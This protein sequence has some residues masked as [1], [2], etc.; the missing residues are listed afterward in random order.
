MNSINKFL[1]L[2]F[3]V[4]AVGACDEILEPEKSNIYTKDRVYNDPLFAEGLML[5]G[6]SLLPVSYGSE[7]VATDDA[8]SNDKT[9]SYLRMATGQWSANYDPMSI[10]GTCYSAI[11]NLNY[12]FTIADDASWSWES[13]VRNEMFKRRLKGEAYALRAYHHMRLLMYYGGTATDGTLRGV[14]YVTEVLNPGNDDWKKSRGTY[15]EC[16]DQIMA[17]FNQATA[18]L[19][20][21]WVNITGYDD[22]T[23]VYGAHNKNRINSQIIKA[24]KARLALHAASP[25][26]NSGSYNTAKCVTAATLA[27]ELLAEIGGANGL[28]AAGLVYYDADNDIN[29]AEVLW[30]NNTYSS[31]AKEQT[32]FPPSLYGNGDINP[33][34]NLVDAFPMVN[35]YPITASGSGYNP[36][37]PYVNRDPRL[38]AYILYDGNK[39]GTTTIRTHVDDPSNGINKLTTSTRTGYYLK[40]LLRPDVNLNPAAIN[41]KIHIYNHVRFTELFLIYAEAANQAWGLDADPNGYG[42][43]PRTVIRAIR[44]RA[45]ITPAADPYLASRT[46]KEEMAGLIRNERRLELCFEGFRF[47]DLRRWKLNLTETTNGMEISGTTYTPISVEARDFESYMYYAPIPSTEI[48]KNEN[49]LQN[50]GW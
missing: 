20:Y 32:C 37:T 4:L 25:A 10:W 17:D 21:K 8:V 2:L 31:N 1:L 13:E 22:S 28:N 42:F 36:N 34:Q 16:Y 35:G 40:K 12:F 18:L 48:L 33:T 19:P 41:T 46:T 45:G 29:I 43:T 7:D 14:P 49:L 3:L 5:R 38:A 39:L 24:L 26:Y 50:Q 15:Q 23:T 6:Y 9:S 11:F 47:W 44:K 30:R 27:G